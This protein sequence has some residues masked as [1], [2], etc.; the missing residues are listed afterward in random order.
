MADGEEVE[1][2]GGGI[3]RG[4]RQRVGELDD[5]AQG[6]G[7]IDHGLGVVLALGG[8]GVQDVLAGGAGQHAGEL[9]AQ[10]GGIAHARVPA[11]AHPHRHQVGGIAGDQ[12][13]ALAEGPCHAAVV[14]EDAAADVGQIVRVRDVVLEH[15]GNPLLGGDHR[16]VLVIV[17]HELP[18]AHR[19]G[20]A[21][22]DVGA[23]G[24]GAEEDI[25]GAQ[26]VVVDVHHEPTGRGGVA[27]EAH[28][29]ALAGRGLAA[30]A[31]HQVLRGK[32]ALCFGAVGGGDA[33]D[34]GDADRRPR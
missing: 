20:Q 16:F 8:V 6:H 12:L 11:L 13:A 15:L 19:V 27:L 7:Q 5:R 33:R 21:D 29:H 10:V 3:A 18:A 32:S 22:G 1:H 2:R 23:L 14:G 26:R 30:L 9:P 25:R 17:E 24:I 34:G 31:A 4:N 28:A